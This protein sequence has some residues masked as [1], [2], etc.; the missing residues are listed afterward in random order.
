M[1]EP[2]NDVRRAQGR[3]AAACRWGTTAEQE[4]ALRELVRARLAAQIHQALPHLRTGDR[5]DLAF[6]LL[7]KGV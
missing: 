4:G 2:E 3:Y 7:G 5:R 1:P 6:A